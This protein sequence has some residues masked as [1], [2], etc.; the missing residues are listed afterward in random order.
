MPTQRGPYNFQTNPAK[1][2]LDGTFADPTEN[3]GGI[4][5]KTSGNTDFEASNY[6]FL[7]FWVLDPFIYDKTNKGE[8]Y[9]NLGKVSEDVIPDGRRMF[10]NGMP[11]DGDFAKVD[12]TSWG[13]VPRSPAPTLAF[14]N[15][16]GARQ[17]QPCFRE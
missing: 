1:V 3:W 12:T 15:D 13:Y 2:K 4:M 11:E 14:S 6:E 8:F 16:A 5:R 9:L 17:F 7:E 10:E